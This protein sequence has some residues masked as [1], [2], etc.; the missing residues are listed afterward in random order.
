MKVRKVRFV[1]A[2]KLWKEIDSL[3]ND[4]KYRVALSA[5]CLVALM[6]AAAYRVAFQ[7]AAVVLWLKD[8]REIPLFGAGT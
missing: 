4:G 6:A 1:D 7:V 5:F 3:Y 8:F 2:P